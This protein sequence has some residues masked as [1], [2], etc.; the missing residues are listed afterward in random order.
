M[1]WKYCKFIG[2]WCLLV[3]GI[4]LFPTCKKPNLDGNVKL[5]FSTPKIT[6]DTVFTTIGSTTRSFTVHNTSKQAVSVDVF[7]AG[8]ATSFFSINVDGVAGTSFQDVLIPAKD[9]IFIHVKVT[10]NPANQNNPFLVTD[11]IVFK[12]EKNIQDVDLIAYGQ[13]A[14]FIVADEW[15]G[16][17]N[18]KIVAGA[19]QT[20]YWRN[21]K[22]YV[23]YG[24]AAVDSLGKLIIE[25]GTRIYLHRGAGIWVYRYGNLQ[26]NGTAEN[27][28]VFQGD[29]REAWFDSDYSQ[30]DRIFINEGME[31]N[32]ISYATIKNAFVGIQ[33]EPL[34]E[35]LTNRLTIQNT[36]VQNSDNAG[37]ISH[38]YNLDVTNCQISNNGDNSLQLGIGNYQFKFV[39]VANY[40]AGAR[41]KPAV[42]LA[43][44]YYTLQVNALGE[45][46]KVKMVGAA[47]FSFV[48]SIVYG[49]LDEE[50]EFLQDDSQ[51]FAYT[52]ENSILRSSVNNSSFVN[53]LRSDPLFVNNL[54][55]DYNLK[56]GSPAINAALNIGIMYDLLGRPRTL[57]GDIGAYE[58]VGQ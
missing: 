17:M 29:R 15:S 7:L 22:P 40:Y 28:V 9:S 20:T 55:Q 5:S 39:T 4:V 19:N 16:S 42:S 51:P 56:N 6:F 30:W 53:C 43:N 48:N 1:N 58:Y 46:T 44:Y 57:P 27:R 11:S 49:Y 2:L 45:V 25:E 37:I 18:Y 24:Y 31:E 50:L 32:K 23:I 33:A 21:D 52:F 41:K 36:I 35:Y 47:N 13:D 38:A 8:G 10:I 54:K 3:M 34:L 12:T 26:V 14:H